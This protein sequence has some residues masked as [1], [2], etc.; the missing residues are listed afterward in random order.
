MTTYYQVLLTFNKSLDHGIKVKTRHGLIHLPN[1]SPEKN[2]YL[3]QFFIHDFNGGLLAI[4]SRNA[5]LPDMLHSKKISVQIQKRY[6]DGESIPVTK[7]DKKGLLFFD[8]FHKPDQND[9]TC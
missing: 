4:V 7:S 9:Q 6:K 5:F 2:K 1:Q 3:N 8:H